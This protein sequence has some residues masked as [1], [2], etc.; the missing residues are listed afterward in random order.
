MCPV[1][2][3]SRVL[4][5]VCHI[6]CV[7]TPLPPPAMQVGSWAWN[8]MEPPL[9]QMSF[10]LLCMQYARNQ[11]TNLGAKP[12]TAWFLNKRAKRVAQEFPDYCAHIVED[13][14]QGDPLSHH[15]PHSTR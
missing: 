5:P 8:W 2:C 13:F 11:L 9:G 1:C 6:C 7:L 10:F 4:Y 12:Y 3:V 14:S 15:D